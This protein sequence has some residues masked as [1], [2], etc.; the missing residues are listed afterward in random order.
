MTAIQWIGVR[1]IVIS[2]VLICFLAFGYKNGW[3]DADWK[4]V[5]SVMGSL[6]LLDW[7]KKLLDTQV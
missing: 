4:T 5:I 3:D 6:G 2:T 7:V 1:Q